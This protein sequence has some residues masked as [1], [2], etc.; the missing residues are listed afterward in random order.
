M[1]FTINDFKRDYSTEEQC[2][3]RL[4]QLKYGK[5][6][7]CPNCGDV[8]AKFKRVPKRRSYWCTECNYQLYP[9]AGTVF[10]KSTT[11]LTHWFYSIFLFTTTRNGVAAKELE[12][13]LGVTYK[14]AWRMAK[15]IRT[16]MANS[17]VG[18]LSGEVIVDETFVGPQEKFKHFNKKKKGGGYVN[19]TPVFGMMEK[20]TN[21]IITKVMKV[22]EI[23]GIH[24]TPILK[25]SIDKDSTI[26]T[27]GFT[28]YKQLSTHFKAHEVVNHFKKQYVNKNGFTT[29]NLEGFWSSMKRMIRGTHIHVSTKY[30][31]LYVAETSFRYMNRNK[32]ETLFNL[33]LERV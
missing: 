31:D 3:E 17:D 33:I 28:G 7:A 1:K 15:Q 4:F 5:L 19:K 20:G 10:E 30:L 6:E 23:D 24:L 11:P 32:P 21:K 26:V 22:E 9:T 16:L 8:N 2:L 25:K 29:N 27:D 12:R 13:Q 18:I 14:T